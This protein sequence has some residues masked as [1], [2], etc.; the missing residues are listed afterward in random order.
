MSLR[1]ERMNWRNMQRQKRKATIG[2]QKAIT[3]NIPLSHL[4]LV[5]ESTEEKD[6]T[7]SGQRGRLTSNLTPYVCRQKIAKRRRRKPHQNFFLCSLT[8]ILWQL[9]NIRLA[10]YTAVYFNIYIYMYFSQELMRKKKQQW[11]IY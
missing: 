4:W 2:K 8:Y 7:H 1:K 10:F 6:R 5:V 3:C 9:L 11:N